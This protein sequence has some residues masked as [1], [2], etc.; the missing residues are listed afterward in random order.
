[1]DGTYYA[2]FNNN[3]DKPITLWQNAST[4]TIWPRLKRTR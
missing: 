4:A 1:M 2:G 3:S